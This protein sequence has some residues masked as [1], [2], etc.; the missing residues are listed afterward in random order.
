[1]DPANQGSPDLRPEKAISYEAGADWHPSPLFRVSVTVFERRET[2]GIDYVR[3]SPA[4]I[5]RA[6]NF[7]DLQFT[8]VESDLRLRLPRNQ[9][10]EFS[11]TGLRGAQTVLGARQSK[12][13]FNYP[14]NS[15]LIA[16]QGELG[17]GFLART[18]IGIVERFNRDP[19]AVWD[20]Y[21]AFSR[22]RFRPFLQFTNLT[23]TRYEEI[24]GVRMQGRAIVGGVE[25]VAF[26][27]R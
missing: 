2:D 22:T 26:G 15:G 25:L 12:Y 23:A 18:R 24:P 7:Q 11:W 3:S 14:V 19:Y 4:A 5:W 1:H 6:T 17:G 20:F 8:G 27:G 13:V 16:W 21:A 9:H 10:L